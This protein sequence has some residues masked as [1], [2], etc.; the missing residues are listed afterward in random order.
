MT[1]PILAGLRDLR[2]DLLRQ[3]VISGGAEKAEIISK[4]MEMDDMIAAEEKSW[5]Q[6]E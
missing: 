5:E 2:E 4:I 6:M 3:L 1:T